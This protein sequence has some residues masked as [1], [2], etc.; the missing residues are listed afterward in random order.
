MTRN[1]RTDRFLIADVAALTGVPAPRLRSWEKSGLLHP[2]RSAGDVRVYGP[3]DVARVRLINRSLV[4][5]GRRGSLRRLAK[6]LASGALQPDPDDYAGLG[7]MVAGP[8]E[9][10]AGVPWATVFDALTDPLA[11]W[12]GEGK[13]VYANR[14]LRAALDANDGSAADAEA[15]TMSTEVMAA[16]LAPGALAPRWTA[17]T[18]VPQED[19]PVVLVPSTGTARHTRWRT[20]PLRGLDGLPRGAVTVGRDVTD[21]ETLVQAREAH[22]AAAARDLRPRAGIVLG[23][24]QLARRTLAAL[25]LPTDVRGAAERAAN[26]S[27]ESTADAAGLDRLGRHLE[28]AEA[29]TRDFLRALDTLLDATIAATGGLLGELV[30]EEVDLRPLADEALAHAQTLTTRHA[31][32]NDVPSTPVLVTGDRGRLR[33]LLD[34]L[35]ANALAYA[36]EGGPVQVRLESVDRAP[37]DVPLPSSAGWAVLRV[38]DEGIGIPDVDLPHVFDRFYRGGNAAGF[39]RGAGLGLYAAR[40]IAASHGGHAW[41]ERTATAKEEERTEWHGTVVAVALPAVPMEASRTRV[42]TSTAHAGEKGQ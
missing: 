25:R 33:E 2:G 8:G 29:G 20:R 32:G 39:V 14:A 19:V 18:G 5:P 37:T 13:L 40:A 41:I 30:P 38:T 24:L 1:T 16:L 17:R 35:L 7:Q 23:N 28:M 42:A 36:P 11:V 12:D 34:N 10:V 9:A 21:V 26:G 31:L 4:N 15:E 3:E 27:G 6:Q 22:L